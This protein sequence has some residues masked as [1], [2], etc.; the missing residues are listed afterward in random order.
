MLDVYGR[1]GALQFAC[2][3][4]VVSVFLSNVFRYLS[5]RILKT[6]ESETIASLRH[7]VFQKRLVCIWAFSTMSAKVI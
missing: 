5:Q 2:A 1:M 6:V 4:I 3:I 7:A